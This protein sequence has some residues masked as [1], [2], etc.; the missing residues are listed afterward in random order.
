LFVFNISSSLINQVIV[1]NRNQFT[2]IA[3]SHLFPDTMSKIED[4]LLVLPE[5]RYKKNDGTLYIMKERVAFIMENR[6]SVQVAHSFYEIKSESNFT[7]KLLL[8][9]HH[10][11]FSRS[12]F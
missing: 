10:Q 7:L 8:T 5:V 1:A 9:F 12:L 4:V 2:F 11:T 3:K 6:D